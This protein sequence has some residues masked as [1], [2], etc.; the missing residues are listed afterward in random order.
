[1]RKNDYRAFFANVK[2]FIKMSYFADLVGISR[3]SISR[4]L[5]GEQFDYE[6]SLESCNRLYVAII[7]HF[8]QFIEIV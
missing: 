8:N 7:E 4:F 1:M 2:P 5:K 3:T 6:M